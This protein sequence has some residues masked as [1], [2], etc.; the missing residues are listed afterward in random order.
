MLWHM[1]ML[2]FLL[3]YEWFFIITSESVGQGNNH[4]VALFCLRWWF[5]GDDGDDD[6]DD[7]DDDDGKNCQ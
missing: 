6:D 7:D 5:C 1:A 3:R 2:H 4:S